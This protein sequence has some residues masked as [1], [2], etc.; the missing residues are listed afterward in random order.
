M[1]EY[2]KSTKIKGDKYFMTKLTIIP[3]KFTFEKPTIKNGKG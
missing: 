2:S 3:Q 1:I